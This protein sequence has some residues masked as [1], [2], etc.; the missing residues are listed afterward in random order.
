MR[1]VL[2]SAVAFA[3][4]SAAAVT[5]QDAWDQLKDYSRVIKDDGLALTLVH[6]NNKTV[7][8]LFQPP[9]LY[10]IRARAN[11]QT[12]FYV[13]GTAEKDVDLLTTNFVATQAGEPINVSTSSIHNF[14]DGKVAKAVRVEGLLVLDKKVDL[15][16]PLSIT[17]GKNSV[18]FKFN[19]AQLKAMNPAPAASSQE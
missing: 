3:L 2:L 6:I 9:A 5:G 1:R 19:D 10:S 18:E 14:Q 4:V 16:K 17:H 7:A 8:T 11:S 13:Q 15:A 12:S